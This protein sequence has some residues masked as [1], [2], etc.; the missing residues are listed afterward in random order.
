MNEAV[1]TKWVDALRSGEYK[2]GKGQLQ[3]KSG[4]FCCLGVL[5]DLAVQEG[6][7][8]APEL[9]DGETFSG[10]RYEGEAALLPKSVQAWAGNVRVG[11]LIDMNDSGKTFKTIARYI[12]KEV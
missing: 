3:T 2:Q 10:Y 11:T 7:L 5:C 9:I 6:V 12:E 1:K 4:N 8:D